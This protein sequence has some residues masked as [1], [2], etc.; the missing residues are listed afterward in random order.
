MSIFL[1]ILIILLV[2]FWPTLRRLYSIIKTVNKARQNY[3]DFTQG[4]G[5]NTSSSNEEENDDPYAGYYHKKRKKIFSKNDG[6]YVK[7][8]E[9]EEERHVDDTEADDSENSRYTESRITD[10]KFEE[11]LDK[12]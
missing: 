5:G 12:K 8:Q 6:E 2:I 7:F 11:I 9:I 1:I 4:F 10:A 3:R